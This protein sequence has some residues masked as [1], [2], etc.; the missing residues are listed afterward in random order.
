MKNFF[1]LFVLFPIISFSQEK[2]TLNETTSLYEYSH[3]KNFEN[4]A[5]VDNFIKNMKTLNYTNVLIDGSSITGENYFSVMVM[6]TPLQVHY[7]VFIDLKETK[8]KLTI[9]KFVIEDKRWSPV[10]LENIKSGKNRWISKIN[11][12]LPKIIKALEAKNDW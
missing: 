7:Y 5:D 8:Y 11:E 6:S 1:L 10:P 4:V 9:N 12:N 2:I 3:V